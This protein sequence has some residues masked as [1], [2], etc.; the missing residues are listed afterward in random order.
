M[1]KYESYTDEQL[2]GLAQEGDEN[3]YENLLG[4]H[5]NKIRQLIYFSVNDQ[6]YVNDLSQ[7]VM[8]KIHRYLPNFKLDSKFSTW[9]Y[10][11]IQNTIKNHYRLLNVRAES[12]SQYVLEYQG[13]AYSPESLAM[14]IEFNEKIETEMAKLSDE[15]RSCYGLHTFEGKSYESIAK[16]MDCPIGTVRSRIFRARK[17]L[18]DSM[19]GYSVG[20]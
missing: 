7:D 6:T 9:L 12:E 4:R 10:P 11:I 18:S 1:E 8:L 16:L 14:S 3:A 13:Q 15:L 19:G 17:L 20:S 2:V 5:F